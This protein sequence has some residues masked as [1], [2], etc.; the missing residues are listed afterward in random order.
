MSLLDTDKLY[1]QSGRNKSTLLLDVYELP[2]DHPDAILQG[3]LH[4]YTQ[5]IKR[6]GTD[7]KRIYKNEQD[8]IETGK[9]LSKMLK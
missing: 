6:K 3:T 2:D 7:G 4:A 9:R 8:K 1:I 5:F